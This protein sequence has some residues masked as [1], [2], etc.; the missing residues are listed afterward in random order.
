MTDEP[1][2]NVIGVDFI[3]KPRPLFGVGPAQLALEG[4]RTMNA[5]NLSPRDIIWDGPL[6]LIQ[7][8]EDGAL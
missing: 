4:I 6:S 5:A 8:E 7:A 1:K 2:S 3:A